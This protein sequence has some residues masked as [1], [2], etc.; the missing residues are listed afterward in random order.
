M[1]RKT[2]H[3]TQTALLSENLSLKPCG[4]E[5]SPVIHQI[6]D[7]AILSGGVSILARAEMAWTMLTAAEKDEY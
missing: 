7:S 6:W 2:N 3:I 4:K 1:T 5:N